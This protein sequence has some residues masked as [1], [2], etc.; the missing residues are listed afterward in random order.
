MSKARVV[1]W[2][3]AVTGSV[4]LVSG[5]EDFLASRV[6]RSLRDG[7]RQT[8]PQLEISQL[9][10]ADYESGRLIELTAPSLFDEPRL[11]IIDGVERCSDALIEDGLS[12]LTD[13]NAESTVVFRHSSGV[14]G[15]KLLD[16]LRNDAA[17][18]EVTCEK[19]AKEPDRLAFATEEFKRLDKKITNAAL[20]DLVAAFGEDS[21]GLAA[22][23]AQ[24]AQ[25][26]AEAIDE[27]VVERYY[28]GRVEV[29]NFKVIDA[30]TAGRA[31]DMLV[32]LRHA[33]GSGQDPVSIIGAIAH[34]VRLM[35]K[36]LNNRTATAQQLSANPWAFDRARKDIVGWTEDGMAAVV[37]EV[38]KADAA[39][40]GAERDPEYA[41]ERLLLLISRKGVPLG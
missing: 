4:V 12:Y 32:L 22:A 27:K 35:A 28:A 17:V 24:L 34:K 31:G 18:V 11:V 16:A 23:C 38:A 36:I 30:A 15:K 40:K 39:V 19:L 5:P 29:D 8:N 37:Q 7:L 25:D 33:F 26:V 2:N 9:D 3:Q 14:R 21:A 6:L 1:K 13:I 20:R 10:A 41:V